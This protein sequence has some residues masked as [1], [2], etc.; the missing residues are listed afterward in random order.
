[1]SSSD[2]DQIK[3]IDQRI[4]A[5]LAAD[6]A[7]GTCVDRQSTG[8]AAQVVFEGDSTPMPVWVAGHVYLEPGMK[9]VLQ[10]FGPKWVVVA[11]P[12]HPAAMGS[13]LVDTFATSENL[14]S[15]TYVDMN[16]ASMSF[17]KVYD[18]TWVTMVMTVSGFPSAVNQ[19]AMFAL[20]FTPVDPGN[21]YTPADIG[22]GYLYMSELTHEHGG[23]A[24]RTGTIPAGAYTVQPRWKRTS[25]AATISANTVDHFT[26]L[27]QETIGPG[28]STL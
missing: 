23:G 8:R 11:S 24:N 18:L 7:Q 20:R 5:A 4:R 12:A 26:F 6:R 16:L 19:A 27:I 25:G 22:V 1:M 3:L 14:T 28:V 13:R 17:T 2:E 10:R 15:S 21:T 9:C